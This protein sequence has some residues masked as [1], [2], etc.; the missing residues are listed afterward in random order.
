[1]SSARCLAVVLLV[2]AVLGAAC[3]RG[4]G[5]APVDL[6]AAKRAYVHGRPI[7]CAAGEPTT[8]Y[9]GDPLYVDDR[10][11]LP[12]APVSGRVVGFEI[13]AQRARLSCEFVGNDPERAFG[14]SIAVVEL[15]ED[16]ELLAVGAPG[17]VRSD[18]R[19]QVRLHRSWELVRSSPAHL[20]WPDASTAGTRADEFGAALACLR[21]PT[22]DEGR[23]AVG[24]PTLGSGG[25]VALFALPKGTPIA[26]RL[27]PAGKSGYGGC[28]AAVPDRD[29][30]GIEDLAVSCGSAG[31]VD[32]LSSA[33]LSVVQSR[34]LAGAA[35]S[36]SML[37]DEL[38]DAQGTRWLA[39]VVERIGDRTLSVQRGVGADTVAARVHA[40]GRHSG[41]GFARSAHLYLARADGAGSLA[42]VFTD[43]GYLDLSRRPGLGASLY[44]IGAGVTVPQGE[45]RVP[46]VHRVDRLD[47][48]EVR[49][50]LPGFV[51]SGL[52]AESALIGDVD[53]RGR[54]DLVLTTS[55]GLDWR[56]VVYSLDA[57]G[58]LFELSPQPR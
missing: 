5:S 40:P 2:A 10:S 46:V 39:H 25:G 42:Y 34:A 37:L 51:N 48:P 31:G 33:D 11:W 53:G 38:A 8:V 32:V 57:D 56:A 9:I 47:A 12:S 19:G 20:E 4:R 50:A 23:L 36:E 26:T 49:T 28:L 29:G 7:A 52:G 15:G 27:G 54:P 35:Y 58:V 6:D 43:A 14:A 22:P 3:F 21:G 41:W 18:V 16:R 17:V 24:A 55:K 44:G 30:D 1:M 13:S 45:L